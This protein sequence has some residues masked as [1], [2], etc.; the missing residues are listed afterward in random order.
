MKKNHAIVPTGS[1]MNSEKVLPLR[2]KKSATPATT[3]P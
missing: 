3:S 1:R 2:R